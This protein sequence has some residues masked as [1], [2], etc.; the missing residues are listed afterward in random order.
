MQL[1]PRRLGRRLFLIGLPVLASFVVSM[2][3]IG[4]SHPEPVGGEIPIDRSHEVFE[5]KA[6]VVGLSWSGDQPP[7]TALI[8]VSEDGVSWADWTEIHDTQDHGPDSGTPEADASRQ[9]SEAVYVGEANWIEVSID[10]APADLRL[11]YFETTG[12]S[13]PLWRRLVDTVGRIRWSGGARAV[14]AIDQPA[15][16]PRSAWGGE[17]CVAGTGDSPRY[18]RRTDVMF[19][20][21]TVHS[22]SSNDY[23]PADVPDLLYAICQYHVN[24]NGWSDIGYNTLIDKFGTVW[25][26][27][28]GGLAEGVVGAHSGGF[29]TYS[30]GV[31][32]IGDHRSLI[33]SAE[34]QAAFI[35]FANW[36]LD[37]HHIDPMSTPLV[38]S[39]GSTRF[40][41]GQMFPLRAISGHRDVSTTTCPGDQLLALIDGF[42]AQIAT[43][44]GPKIYGGKPVR[45]PISG[46]QTAGYEAMPF[47]FSFT[48]NMSWTFRILDPSGTVLVNQTGQGSSGE[49]IWDGTFSGQAQPFGYYTS[50]L[51]ATPS[52]GAPAPRPARFLFRLGD[53]NPPFSDDDGSPHETDIKR[54][55][56]LGIT[57][58][59][60]LD[61]FCPDESVTRWQMALFLTRLHSAAGFSLPSGEG[62]PFGDIA[63]YSAETQTAIAQLAALGVTSGT[64][65]GEFSPADVVTRWQMAL[66]LTRILEI[67]GVTLP[68]GIDQGFTDLSGLSPETVLAIN[69]IGQLGVTTGIGDGLYGPSLPVTRAQM[70]SFLIR[71]LAIINPSLVSS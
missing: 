56:D 42:R 69:Q 46:S 15:V 21:H 7:G 32:F 38:K 27:R 64:G 66:F 50:E 22:A 60:T 35:Q 70:A 19:V 2:A 55:F 59:C 52:S 3:D 6:S 53:Y 36:K 1:R 68:E 63:G 10:R 29:N 23:T 8:R 26:G 54:I 13:L 58:G 61:R 37:I 51:V 62:A 20:H 30:T 49:V 65:D 5:V 33:P 12:R 4:P 40:P 45:D 44:G 28:A 14:A 43:M 39:L 16:Q 9:T 34:A 24:A 71:S 41:E 18:S 25:E 17:A 67:D 47:R 48:E 57:A 11:V 31:A